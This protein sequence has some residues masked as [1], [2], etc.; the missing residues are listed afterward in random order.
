[1]AE[2]E[3]R[4]SAL[5]AK[6]NRADVPV[7]PIRLTTDKE[8]PRDSTGQPAGHV[9]YDTR[10]KLRKIGQ[11]LILAI[12]DPLSGKITTAEADVVPPR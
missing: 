10:L 6:G 2:L 8:P 4:V 3:L 11:H 5:D 12:F 7:I 9:R 1:V